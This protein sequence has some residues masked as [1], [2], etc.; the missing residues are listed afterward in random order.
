MNIGIGGGG[1][2]M[3]M[4]YNHVVTIYEG[5]YSTAL[6]G[7]K[8]DLDLGRKTAD[9]RYVDSI[10]YYTMIGECFYREGKFADAL[11]NYN[12][13]LRLQ[14]AFPDWMARV[15]FPAS[16][17]ASAG[18][19]T[20]PW[21]RSN[22]TAKIWTPPQNMSVAQ[23]ELFLNLQANSSKVVAPPQYLQVGVTEII[24]CT[25]LAL[26]RRQE[27]MGPVCPNDRFS[28]DLFNAFSRR[29]GQQNHWS[30]GWVDAELAMANLNVGQA[31]QAVALLK[32]AVT[33]GGEYDHQLTPMI[34]EE[35]GELSIDAGDYAAASH[36][37][38]EASYS[39][40]AFKDM[41][42]IEE[43]FRYGQQAHLLAGGHGIFPPLAAAIQWASRQSVARELTASLLLSLS[44]GYA[45]QG[46]HQQAWKHLGEAQSVIERHDMRPMSD[47]RL[48]S[49]I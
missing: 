38:E 44:E 16:I 24:R 21:G 2:P 39:A 29:P 6:A 9:S 25:V 41:T 30:E 37:L 33:L 4:Y 8:A 17:Q 14:L 36:Y 27:I 7:Y 32:R 26:K 12:A 34:L 10:C 45:L 20:T 5:D 22:R 48:G 3:Q 28:E 31:G 35:L 46:E 49:T 1:L 15:Q 43:A 13:A 42:V 23:G 11:D 18:S 40:Y 47:W 19:V